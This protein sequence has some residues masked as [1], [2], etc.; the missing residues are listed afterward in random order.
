MKEPASSSAKQNK[1]PL[2]DAADHYNA[3]ASQYHEQYER[4]RLY[5]ANTYPAN[6][7]RL[8][9]LIN[10]MVTKGVKTLYEVGVGEGTPI[11]TLARAGIDVWGCDIAQNMVDRARE[12]VR[13]AGLDAGRISWGDIEDSTT[14]APV[15]T[16]APFDALIA[17]GVMPHVKN[18]D[19]A[20]TNMTALVKPGGTI[21]LEFRNKLF[22]L[23][24]FNRHTMEFIMD[25]LLAG[26]D[27]ALKAS[28]AK[29]I[30]PRLRMDLP[31]ARD[32]VSASGKPGYDAILSK[33]HNPFEVPALFSRHGFAN[34]RYHWYHYHAAPPLLQEADLFRAESIKL[35]HEPSGWRGY[36]LCSAFV[37]E[38]DKAV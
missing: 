18:D 27:P 28:V 35:E 23:F 1:K 12:N 21:F 5:T 4:E 38:A 26:V 37:I 30:E 9:L 29:E 17:M 19:L 2:G 24:T 14:Y 7:F 22:S 13:S 16:H 20:F 8:Q 36:F 34:L 32:V 25:D 10:S 31:P 3:V 33:F 15:F 6:Y 11:A